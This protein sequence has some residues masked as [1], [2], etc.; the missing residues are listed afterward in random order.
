MGVGD[1]HGNLPWGLKKS[2]ASQHGKIF[3]MHCVS[4]FFLL[5][6]SAFLHCFDVIVSTDWGSMSRTDID[7]LIYSRR[8]GWFSEVL[9][10]TKDEEIWASSRSKSQGRA[11]VKEKNKASRKLIFRTL[12]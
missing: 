12:R 1:V 5:V 3:G 6:I 4:F 8:A 9:C 2:E 10:G 11:G 7:W